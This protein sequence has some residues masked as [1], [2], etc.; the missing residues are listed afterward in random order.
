[1]INQTEKKFFGGTIRVAKQGR[2]ALPSPSSELLRSSTPPEECGRVPLLLQKV[3]SF[4]PDE[5]VERY[6][7]ILER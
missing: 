7:H 5:D 2:P 3:Y 6:Q 1:M 4:L